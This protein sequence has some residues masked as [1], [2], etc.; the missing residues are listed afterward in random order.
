VSTD[1]TPPDVPPGTSGDIVKGLLAE[2]KKR[3]DGSGL[4]TYRIKALADD[5]ILIE[6]VMRHSAIEKFADRGRETMEHVLRLLASQ[7]T[8]TCPVTKTKY[9]LGLKLVKLG[10]EEFNAENEWDSC[11]PCDF[12]DLCQ[13]CG[14]CMPMGMFSKSS[15]GSKSGGM[16][17]DT[18]PE[19]MQMFMC[20]GGGMKPGC[21][22]CG[23]WGSAGGMTMQMGPRGPCGV[24]CREMI[25]AQ[26][27]GLGLIKDGKDIKSIDDC[28]LMQ[29]AAK[30]EELMAESLDGLRD[31]ARA[32]KIA[33]KPSTF[34]NELV[35]KVAA[36]CPCSDFPAMFGSKESGSA[37]KEYLEQMRSLSQTPTDERGSVE[38]DDDVEEEVE[39]D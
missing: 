20:M 38:E 23:P 16:W 30:A 11:D 27:C 29:V 1:P 13:M 5:A 14:P 19:Q 39:E 32:N 2:M 9:A 22:P 37:R 7:L 12:P 24:P 3:Y 17:G 10:S 8:A 18:T 21:G 15:S 4:E 35:I 33:F 31:Q 34:W 25:V 36:A 28:Q 6:S 26:L